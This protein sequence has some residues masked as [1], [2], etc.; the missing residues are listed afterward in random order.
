MRLAIIQWTIWMG[1]CWA[2]MW[3]RPR[4]L[5]S[6]LSLLLPPSRFA[7]R[8]GIGRDGDLGQGLQKN[9]RQTKSTFK[10][11]AIHP[12]T[13]YIQQIPT[14]NF[15]KDGMLLLMLIPH[16]FFERGCKTDF[17]FAFNGLVCTLVKL[18]PL[19][20]SFS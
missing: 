15:C 5:W 20:R 18:M 17:I 4:F 1:L 8:Q 13:Y 12:S 11:L 10:L 7:A 2:S 16:F 3:E 14:D 9:C 19:L 6:L